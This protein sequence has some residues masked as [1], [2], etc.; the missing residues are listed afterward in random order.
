VAFFNKANS[1]VRGLQLGF[2][3]ITKNLQGV[4]IG[5]VN[6]I[7]TEKLPVMVIVNAKF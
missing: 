2:I 5:F 3:N 4:Q 1:V 7:K 6:F